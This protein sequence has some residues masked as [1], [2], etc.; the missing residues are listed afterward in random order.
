VLMRRRP[1]E[2]GVLMPPALRGWHCFALLVGLLT[3]PGRNNH[4]GAPVNSR[5]T[6]V[7]LG[8]GL[9]GAILT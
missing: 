9:G 3:D 5:L 8:Q 2:G 6:F 4:L 1:L 7:A